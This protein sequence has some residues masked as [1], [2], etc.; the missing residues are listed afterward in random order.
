MRH[1]V[2]RPHLFFKL[3]VKD[4]TSIL[5][6]ILCLDQHVFRI[7]YLAHLNNPLLENVSVTVIP[8]IAISFSEERFLVSLGTAFLK[9]RSPD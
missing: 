2:G 5:I 6:K 8:P 4:P 9:A 3:R 1:Q 7:W